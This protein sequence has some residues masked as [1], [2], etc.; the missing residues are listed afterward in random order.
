MIRLAMPLEGTITYLDPIRELITFAA[1]GQDD[2]VLLKSDGYPTYHLAAPVDDHFMRVTLVVRGE[3]WIPSVPKYLVL[4]QALGWTLPTI[5]HTPL[6]RDPKRRKLSKSGG[7][8]S[9]HWFRAQGYL[10]EAIHNW[11]TRLL[12]THPE[13]KD[14]YP[15]EDFIQGIAPEA[16]PK[17]GPVADLKL[18]EFL[19]GA[20]LRQ[21][22]ASTLYEMTSQWLE[23][24]LSQGDDALSIEV[25][26]QQDHHPVVISARDLAAFQRAF[27]A[28][29]AFSERVLS[30]EPERYRK[31]G[32][33]PVLT[34]WFYADLFVPPSAALLTRPIQGARDVADT[35]LRAYLHQCQ[36][37]WLEGEW[38]QTTVGLA[39]Q[40]GV[41]PGAVFMLLRVAVTGTERTPPLYPILQVLGADEVSHRLEAALR[42]VA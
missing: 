15:L 1:E 24:L 31:L 20:Y 19:S 28:D 14:V 23:W 30:L 33:I 2:P 22:S 8:T 4:Y 16:L 21:Q 11:I 18:L 17:T 40:H 39:Q 3:E 7:D 37:S 9:L 27:T 10:P 13:G 32:D 25:F 34:R 41:K 42:A 36:A 35:L 12:W 29:R 5:V 6:L 38:H 26:E